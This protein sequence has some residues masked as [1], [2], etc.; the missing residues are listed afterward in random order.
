VQ[1]FREFF[2]ENDFF[3]VT[4]PTLVQCEVEGGST[5]FEVDYFGEPVIE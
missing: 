4:P 2:F 1:A 3:E 5:L